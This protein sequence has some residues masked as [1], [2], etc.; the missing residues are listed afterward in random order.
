[1]H[2]GIHFGEAFLGIVTREDPMA[3]LNARSQAES[4]ARCTRQDADGGTRSPP[5][6]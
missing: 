3:F 4:L 1:M 5:Y 6:V 2:E